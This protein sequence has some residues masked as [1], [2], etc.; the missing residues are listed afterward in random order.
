MTTEVFTINEFCL[1]HRIS[2]ATFYNLRK[3]GQGPREMHVGV[4]VRIS[5]EAAE[6]WRREREADS[7]QP[8]GTPD[9][10]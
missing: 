8:A 10:V 2:R 4:G 7:A 3:S 9:A 6:E 5:K 1:A